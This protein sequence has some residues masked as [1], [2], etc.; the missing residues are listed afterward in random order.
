MRS[1]IRLMFALALT[2]VA[3][4][5]LR[6]LK[7][8][9]IA[10]RG[11]QNQYQRTR[12]AVSSLTYR[13]DEGRD[14]GF[15]V[16][17]ATTSMR[18]VV[19]GVVGRKHADPDKEF[20]FELGF[21][22]RDGE[23]K[24]L[25]SGSY[26]FLSRISRDPSG[27]AEQPPQFFEDR[28]WQ[29]T[30]GRASVFHVGAW[31]APPETLSFSLTSRDAEIDYL[32]LRCYALEQLPEDEAG[33]AW[34]RIPRRQRRELARDNIYPASRLNDAERTGLMRTRWRPL[35]PTGILGRDYATQALYTEDRANPTR[36]SLPQAALGDGLDL[37]PQHAATYVLEKAENGLQL[38]LA[39][40][41][42]SGPVT[43]EV[44]KSIKFQ[45]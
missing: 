17:S 13:L 2:A 22:W 28:R 8:D 26:H 31:D 36:Q 43:L 30:D 3:V 38:E 27:M 34:N 18:L 41:P 9:W 16:P 40:V 1:L 6:D 25:H 39:T 11:F 32:V 12:D 19:N 33:Q 42:G 20:A 35:G 10:G 29:P 4:L 45:H 15:A 5:L 7:R 14:L 24:V 21:S 23:G 44:S 37:A